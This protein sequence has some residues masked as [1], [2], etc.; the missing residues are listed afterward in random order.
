MAIQPGIALTPLGK[1]GRALVL[2]ALSALFLAGT[3]V[4]QD[5]WWPFSPWR[6]FSTSTDPNAS[7]RSTLIE[8][9]DAAAP[10]IW[11]PAPIEPDSVGLNR[12]EVEG[13]LDQISRDPGMLG[14]LA[15]SHARLR[16]DEPAWIG[17]R[18][19]V[20]H[21]LLR[22]GQPTGEHRNEVIAQWAG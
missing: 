6:M 14:T 17:V 18:V 12:A 1:A 8:V 4:G 22:G 15:A 10:A 21:F 16:P 9:R 3:T 2:L 5:E 13:R 11:R 19:V 7:V 20:R